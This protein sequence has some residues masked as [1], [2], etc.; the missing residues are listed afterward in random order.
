M[1]WVVR[2][3]VPDDAAIYRDIRLEA[4]LSEPTAFSS[5]PADEAGRALE[6]WAAQL[7][8]AFSFG[9]FDG[10]V[11]MGI[12]TFYLESRQKTTHR[13]HVV[14]VYVRPE[15]RGHGAGRALFETLIESARGR[16]LQLELSVTAGNDAARRLYE[17]FGFQ[18]YGTEPR[19]LF[20]EGRYHDK[21]LMM[22][23]LDEGSRKVTSN[24]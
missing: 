17:G 8:R 14:S 21:Y 1:D 11:L 18:L 10:A 20:A 7:G 4:L 24:E 19:G 5:S 9:A 12:A 16:V 22:L 3:L 2:R 15:A 6:E 23:R 13:G